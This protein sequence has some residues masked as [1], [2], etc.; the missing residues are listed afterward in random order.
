METQYKIY[1]VVPVHI[2]P[3]KEWIKSLQLVTEKH[4]VVIV[5]DSDGIVQLPS[6]WD[7]YDYARQ[8]KEDY[9]LIEDKEILIFQYLKD[10]PEYE[11]TKAWILSVVSGVIASRSNRGKTT[12]LLA[13]KS[14]PAFETNSDLIHKKLNEVYKSKGKSKSGEPQATTTCIA[15]DDISIC[16]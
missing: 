7:V 13:E 8:C 1:V 16:Y 11:G 9:T 5:D 4:K 15:T 14:I 6:Q 2:A 12:L 3:S 10:T